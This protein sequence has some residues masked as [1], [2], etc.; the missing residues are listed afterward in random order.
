MKDHINQW[1]SDL[2]SGRYRYESHVYAEFRFINFGKNLKTNN[3]IT[4]KYDDIFLRCA[5]VNVKDKNSFDLYI[6]FFRFNIKDIFNL[7]RLK[8]ILSKTPME[9]KDRSS[10]LLDLINELIS[11]D[12][13]GHRRIYS[14]YIHSGYEN[15]NK[16]V[17]TK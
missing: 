4:S 14:N 1:I 15:I 8:N 10:K 2:K 7:D 3:M 9:Y 6:C 5:Y 13:V 11:S 17:S 12:L 16:E